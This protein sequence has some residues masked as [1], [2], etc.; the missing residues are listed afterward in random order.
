MIALRP[1]NIGDILDGAITAIRR[2]PLLILGIGAVMAVITAGIT[3]LVQ[4]YVL[5]DLE[6]FASTA[7][8]GPGATEEELQSALFGTFGEL[9]LVLI[10]TLL[11]STCCWRPSP[12][13]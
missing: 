11:I 13:A 1:L 3:F 9:F 2:H 4:K 5:A 6:N 10:P 8:L 12:P 7:T